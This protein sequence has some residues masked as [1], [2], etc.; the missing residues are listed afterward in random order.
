LESGFIV[1]CREVAISAN[2]LVQLG[3]E[4]DFPHSARCDSEQW[5]EFVDD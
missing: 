3:F 2:F 5:L 1:F 4:T